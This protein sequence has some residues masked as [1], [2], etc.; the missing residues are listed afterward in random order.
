MHQSVV[1]SN[2]VSSV[3]IGW[4]YLYLIRPL[5]VHSIFPQNNYLPFIQILHVCVVIIF[6]LQK[7][8]A[9]TYV[10]IILLNA[11]IGFHKAMMHYFIVSRARNESFY[12]GIY[13]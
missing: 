2:V 8:Y 7:V 12:E 9:Y 3:T 1:Q 5:N 4:L 11:L 6:L 10:F 13:P